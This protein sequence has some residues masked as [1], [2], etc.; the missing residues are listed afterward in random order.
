M[1][2]WTG[3]LDG[4]EPGHSD[5]CAPAMSTGDKRTGR[6]VKRHFGEW[7]AAVLPALLEGLA[8]IEVVASPTGLESILRHDYVLEITA[9]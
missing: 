8:P 3:I 7:E 1:G 9:A 6:G 4:F 2:V 5:K